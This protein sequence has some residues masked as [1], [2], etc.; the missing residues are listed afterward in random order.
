ME[1]PFDIQRGQNMSRPVLHAANT[2]HLGASYSPAVTS[3]RDMPLAPVPSHDFPSA[4]SST[5]LGFGSAQQLREQRKAEQDA[6]AM[7]Q[8]LACRSDTG[9]L[10]TI[11][12]NDAILDFH[13]PKGEANFPLF[14]Q[15]DSTGFDTAQLKGFA[16]GQPFGNLQL[17]RSSFGSYVSDQLPANIQVP[18]QHLFIAQQPHQQ[19]KATSAS[20]SSAAPSRFS[21]AKSGQSEPAHNHDSHQPTRPGANGGTYTCTYHGCALRFETPELLQINNLGHQWQRRWR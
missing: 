9:T 6:Q 1:N 15:Q 4:I 5:H 7:L 17:N 14:S 8:Q 19:N 3:S 2:Q 20:N 10:Q 16:P 13:F 11:S 12:P 18:Q 21:S